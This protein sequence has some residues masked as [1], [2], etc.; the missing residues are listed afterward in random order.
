MLV[1]L[2]SCV[3]ARTDSGCSPARYARGALCALRRR[4]HS[5][6]RGRDE[7]EGRGLGAERAGKRSGGHATG[8]TITPLVD[9]CDVCWTVRRGRA[10]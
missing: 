7:A 5:G 9:V 1:Q 4:A 10:S 2:T 6:L 3:L 8:T